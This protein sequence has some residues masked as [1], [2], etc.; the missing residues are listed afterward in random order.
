MTLR[1]LITLVGDHSLLMA[2][3]LAV[4]PLAAIALTFVVKRDAGAGNR[5]RYVYSVLVYVACIPG[6]FAA[7][8][9]AYALF[10]TSKNLL[11]V[12][13]LVYLLPLIAMGVTLVFVRKAVKLDDVP[14]FDRLSGLMVMLAMT[15]A[16]VL[17]I[18]KTRIWVVFFGSLP[19]LIGLV[20]GIFAL[21]KWGSYMFF[22]SRDE[23]KRDPPSILGD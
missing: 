1:E 21:L 17:G 23:P 18:Q 8:L 14:G 13:V 16:L 7:V 5:L 2:G 6:I 11:D 19:M 20:V 15:F 4:P 3:L 10:F 9:T 22:R 12:N